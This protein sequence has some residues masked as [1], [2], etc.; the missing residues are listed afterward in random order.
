VEAALLPRHCEELLRRSNPV[1][2][3]VL[4]CFASLAMTVPLRRERGPPSLPAVDL[5]AHQRDRLLIN[6]CG[7]PGL[8]GREVGLARLV[9]SAGAPAV[10]L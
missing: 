10:R 4:D 1:R 9:A 6:A 8:D 7:V 3:T 5:P 2:G